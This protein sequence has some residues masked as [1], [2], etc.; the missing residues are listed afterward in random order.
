MSFKRSVFLLLFLVP[1]LAICQRNF[2]LSGYVRDSLSGETLIGATVGLQGKSKGITSNQFGF[3]SISLPRGTYEFVCTY[4]G[5]QPRIFQVTLDR[6][7]EYNLNLMQ[8]VIE[9]KA[10]VISGKKRDANIK[11]AQMG[12]IDLSMNEIKA[13]PAFLGEV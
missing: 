7:V 8:K 12:K 11:S 10:I 5:Y 1:Q 2:T 6:D 3:Y 13:I 9:E 4:V